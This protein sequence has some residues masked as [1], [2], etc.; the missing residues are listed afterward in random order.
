MEYGRTH[1]RAIGPRYNQGQARQQHSS[2]QAAPK[3]NESSSLLQQLQDCKEELARQKGLKEMFINK[4]KATCEEL[5]RLKRA[6][7]PEAMIIFGIASEARRTIKTKKK[8]EL[9]MEYE[10]MKTSYIILERKS[11]TELQLEREE[12]QTLL[13][14]LEQL[15]LQSKT[16]QINEDL[17]LKEHEATINENEALKKKVVALEFDINFL[18]DNASNEEKSFKTFLKDLKDEQASI[19][20]HHATKLQAEEEINQ[21]LR[22]QLSQLKDQHEDNIAEKEALKK[23]VVALEL[24][25]QLASTNQEQVTE[26]NAEEHVSHDLQTEENLHHSPNVEELKDTGRNKKLEREEKQTLLDELEQL[27]LQSKTNQINEDLKLKE[28]EATINENEALKKKVVA[29]EFDINFLKDN[30]S[31]EEKSFKTFLKD[32]KDEQ[33]SIYLHHAT[34]LQAE[35][36]INQALR[37]QLNQLKDQHED[38]IAEKEALKKKVVALE[39]EKQLASTNQEQV[40]ET[41]AEEHVSH[42]LQTEENLHHSPNV[43]ELKDTG[44]NKKVKLSIWKKFK[45]ISFSSAVK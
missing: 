43:E 10:N 37:T 7:D 3:T 30:A 22:T 23:K 24:E 33:A 32:L 19:Y 12:K 17:K 9:Q 4:E 20:L 35:E 44:R 31:K 15:K 25:K 1:T 45:R 39:L 11:S 13:D 42:D 21:A 6:S 34:K 27:K 26:T 28:H 16:N 41:N 5:E 2:V 18:K 40:T 29:L 36:E 38:N 8:K 14:E